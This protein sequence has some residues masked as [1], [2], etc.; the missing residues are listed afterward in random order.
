MNS[1]AEIGHALVV[2]GTGML[3]GVCLQLARNGWTVSVIARDERR[4][5]ALTDESGGGITPMPLDYRDPA[6]LS[7]AICARIAAIGPISLV[8]AWIHVTS[9]EATQVIAAVAS[10]AL[11][12]IVG[13]I[14][15]WSERPH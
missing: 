15:P 12:S 8:I 9:R 14:E 6:T 11:N 10:G 1:D 2:G 7:A 3:R 5:Q 4:L 13:I